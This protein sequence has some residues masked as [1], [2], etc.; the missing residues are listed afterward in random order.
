MNLFDIF[1]TQPI[2][3]L[4]L[5]IY[6]FVGDFGVDSVGGG[7][8]L[9]VLVLIG[10]ECSGSDFV[11]AVLGHGLGIAADGVDGGVDVLPPS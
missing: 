7:V 8:S 4:L 5:V 2:F 1:I 11:C 9:F 6:N 10:R 3:N